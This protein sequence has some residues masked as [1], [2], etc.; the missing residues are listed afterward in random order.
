M[1]A[2]RLTGPRAGPLKYDLITAL[3]SWG[4][5]QPPR[6]QIS[7]LRLITL[8]T[9]RYNWRLDEFCVGQRDMARMW[10][11]TERTVKREVKH[12]CDSRLLICKRQGVR[13]RVGAYRLN[14][15]ELFRI[16]Q[17]VWPD[18][19][20]DFADRMAQAN[21]VQSPTVVPVDFRPQ[22]AAPP[23]MDH[24]SWGAVCARIH[25]TNPDTYTAWI[26]PLALTQDSDGTLILTAP[27]R[28]AARYIE[29]HL[30]GPLTEAV[31]AALGPRDRIILTA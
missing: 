21:P 15:P 2:K 13:G 18:V 25:A 6:G 3:G 12:W 5:Q 10:G 23:P 11:V 31:E 22:P 8:I 1:D 28:F 17:P 16:T 4:A 30:M 29:T 24:G 19:G 20:P 26:A 7:A 27:T 14:Y 9:A